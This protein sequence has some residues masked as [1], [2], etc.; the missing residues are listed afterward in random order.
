MRKN[1]TRNILAERINIKLGYSKE[2]AKEFIEFFL[3]SIKVN[4]TSQKIIKISNLASF[5]VIKKNERIGRNPKT[6]KEAIVSERK[7]INC[8]FSK[9]LKYKINKD[10]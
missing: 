2:E 1:F 4:I 7:V 10:N 6:G 5:K 8:K 3:N 9:H